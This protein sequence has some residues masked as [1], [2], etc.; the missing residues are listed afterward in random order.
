MKDPASLAYRREHYRLWFEYLRLAR[1]SSDKAV[2]RALEQSRAFYAP[3]GTDTTIT[4]DTWWKTHAMLFEDKHQIR[5]LR[6]GE[7][8]RV[9][10]RPFGLNQAAILARTSWFA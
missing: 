3:W 6:P 8:P 7:P 9:C 4:F 10:R 1:L 5:L 2:R